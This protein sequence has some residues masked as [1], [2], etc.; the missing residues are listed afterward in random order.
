MFGKNF[1]GQ[2]W[3]YRLRRIPGAV[4]RRRFREPAP[5]GSCDRPG[6]VPAGAAGMRS[7][8]P[9]LSLRSQCSVHSRPGPRDQ[10]DLGRG[11]QAG[12]TRGGS[13][14]PQEIATSFV[15]V[16]CNHCENPPCVRVCPTGA[17][18]VKSNGIV[19]MDEHCCIGCRYCRSA[20]PYGSRSFNY[21]D[22]RPFLRTTNANYP[23]RARGVVE[24]CTF[25]EE[26]LSSGKRPL[27][28]EVCPVQTMTF[29]DVRD[30]AIQARLASSKILRRRPELG[31]SPYVF[32]IV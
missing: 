8:P 12:L 23:A 9:G 18:F 10:V 30:P 21:V 19:G 6:A 28:V 32:Y 2:H 26:R 1:P 25:C 31:T 13:S 22:P 29:G 5:A 17:T 14:R 24:K 11:A 15:A 16:L 3:R 27:C 20:C 4:V 7:L